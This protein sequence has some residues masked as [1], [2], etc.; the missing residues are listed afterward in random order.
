MIRRGR[1]SEHRS[2]PD[3]TR[4]RQRALDAD[5]G[6]SPRRWRHGP[7]D[8]HGRR[9]QGHAPTTTEPLPRSCPIARP[10]R[11]VGRRRSRC[12]AGQRPGGR[13]QDDVGRR[14][15]RSTRRRDGMAPDRRGRRRSV[16]F[17]DL[18]RCGTAALRS[19]DRRDRSN[20]ARRRARCGDRTSRQRRCIGGRRG[21][22]RLGR[23]PPDFE[24]RRAPQRRATSLAPARELDRARVDACGPTVS[25]RSAPGPRAAVRDP[26]PPTSLPT[27][28]PSCSTADVPSPSRATSNDWA[29]SSTST[30]GW[31]SS[32]DGCRS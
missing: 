16:T 20:R 21:R 31:R 27:T 3:L 26:Q 12:R 29:I 25:P 11:R 32:T 17:L 5:T 23:L 7:S 30:K 22:A 6:S 24:R 14:L 28:R 13:R 4:V 18:R 15:A 1:V 8:R 10:A 19:G 2:R 9:H